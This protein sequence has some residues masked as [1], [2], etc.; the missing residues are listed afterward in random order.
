MTST[1]Q[2]NERDQEGCFTFTVEKKGETN[3]TKQTLRLDRFE[4][5]ILQIT[6]LMCQSY[7]HPHSHAWE[8]A[9]LMS[10]ERFGTIGGGVV[11][12]AVLE[13]LNA[14]RKSRRT[15]FKFTNPFCP[16]CR[17]SVSECEM[18]LLA[19]IKGKRTAQNQRVQMEAVILCEGFPAQKFLDSV[20]ALIGTFEGLVQIAEKL[21][22]DPVPS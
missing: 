21:S 19:I 9:L 15:T 6:Q 17:A 18:R 2:S 16:C 22:P 7:A 11:A 14:L 8:K 20:D 1:K 5:S 12:T 4:H 13:L 10:K 3:A